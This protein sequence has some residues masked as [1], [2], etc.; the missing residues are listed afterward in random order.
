MAINKYQ[1]KSVNG[2][3]NRF[4][5]YGHEDHDM[6]YR[7]RDYNSSADEL[8][9]GGVSS[10]IDVDGITDRVMMIISTDY[11]F[12]SHNYKFTKYSCHKNGIFF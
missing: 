9:P 2:H 4:F 3:P 8:I 5:G 7:L 1:Y 6:A 11:K 10:L 12:K